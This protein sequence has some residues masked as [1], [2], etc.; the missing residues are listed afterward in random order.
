MFARRTNSRNRRE[1]GPGNGISSGP[2]QLPPN[3]VTS[4]TKRF[5]H[6]AQDNATIVP[7]TGVAGWTDKFLNGYDV[8]QATGSKQPTVSAA[9]FGGRQSLRFTS[10]SS[11]E[12]ILT[13]GPKATALAGGTDVAYVVYI[14]FQLATLAAGAH[15]LFQVDSSVSA[16][17]YDLTYVLGAAG[18][19][20]HER[21]DGVGAD[22]N[23]AQSGAVAV[24]GTASLLRAGY[25]GTDANYV[26]NG[27][28]LTT[29]GSSDVGAMTLDRIIYGA[30]G[31]GAG[32]H[33][34]FLDGF[35][36]ESVGFTGTVNPAEEALLT[37][38]FK[39]KWGLSF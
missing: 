35:I 17:T 7:G 37:N 1:C 5:W 30:Y 16:A 4:A 15:V 10:A 3:A 21:R 28:Q 38:Y 11:Q 29:A 34:S 2:Q 32:V 18:T 9:A 33:N 26:L 13:D 19:P 23:R 8:A 31:N 39:A 25:T 14:V 36:G 27:V 6:D 22:T 12:L 24:V 20:F